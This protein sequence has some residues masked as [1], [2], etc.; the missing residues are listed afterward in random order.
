MNEELTMSNEEAKEILLRPLNMKNV[1]QD[2]LEAHKIAIKA[3]D[4]QTNKGKWIQ[5]WCEWQQYL[6][7]S[8]YGYET[9]LRCG[10]NYCPNCGA[11]MIESEE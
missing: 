5:S 9:G 4:Q 8:K 6:E 10:T 1:P 7:C 3:L 2:V 11:R